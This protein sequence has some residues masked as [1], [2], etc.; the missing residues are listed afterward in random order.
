M[1]ASTHPSTH[2]LVSREDEQEMAGGGEGSLIGIR[3]PTRSI[4]DALQD[5]LG[6]PVIDEA[7]MHGKYDY[8][9]TS[10]LGGSEAAFDLAHQLGFELERADRPV[11]MLIVKAAH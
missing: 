11:E 5:L 10:T 2:F 3:Q 8:S 9:A 6:V 1:S 7:G 4:A